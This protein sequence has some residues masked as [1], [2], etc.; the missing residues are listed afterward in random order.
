[1]QVVPKNKVFGRLASL[2]VQL[3]TTGNM[4]CWKCKRWPL[5]II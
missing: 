2:R 3:D 5:T 4:L 1:M